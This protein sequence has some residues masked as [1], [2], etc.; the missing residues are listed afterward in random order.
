MLYRNPPFKPKPKKELFSDNPHVE[1]VDLNTENI[2]TILGS[3]PD[4]IIRQLYINENKNLPV[5]IAFIDGLINNDFISD[6]ILKPIAQGEKFKNVKTT[7][8]AI[9]KIAAGAVYYANQKS[10]TDINDAV[11]DILTANAVLV[12]DSEKTAISFDIKGFEKRSMTEPAD[13]PVLKGAKDTFIEAIRANT[14]TVRRR[15]RTPLLQI[16]ET[17]VGRQSKTSVA[18]I[19]LKGITNMDFVNELKK[20]ID[21]IDVDDVNSTV[22]IEE[23]IADHKYSV[24]PQ[25]ITTERPDKFC[26]NVI[27]GRVGLIIDGLPISIIIPGNIEEFMHTPEDYSRNYIVGSLIR[28][29]RYTNMMATLILPG[30]FIAVVTYHTEMIPTKLAISIAAS[31]QGVPFPSFAEV[32][33]M[34]IA[35]ET[36]MEAGFRLPVSIG[37][38]VS[39]IGGLVIG[40]AA[41]S[42]KLVSQAVVV[43]I[44]TSAIASFFIPNQD[45]ANALRVWRFIIAVLSSLLGIF[46]LMVGLLLL[47]YSVAVMEC[48]GVPYLAPYVRIESSQWEDSLFR[49]PMVWHK[50]RPYYLKTT[51]EQRQK[52]Q[53]I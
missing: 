4:I 46:G 21:R 20:R 15:I 6:F 35:F 24:F 29:L 17:V 48:F 36:L 45:F 14:A 30:F 31:K 33:I 53:G 38:T 52:Q 23:Y 27:S 22:F 19:Y 16:E 40:Q 26:S 39:L 37:Q 32:I 8:E 3:S 42:A 12:F 2:K 44:A 41:V 7:Q 28:L 49:L 47:L 10:R 5:T 25:V 11:N 50:K 51:N 13:E 9:E 34:L 18:I 1:G 43:V